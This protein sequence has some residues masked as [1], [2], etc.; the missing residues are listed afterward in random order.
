MNWHFWLKLKSN[1]KNT[2]KHK[3][4][5]ELN[6]KKNLKITKKKNDDQRTKLNEINKKIV[7]STPINIPKI[8]AEP[9]KIDKRTRQGR[10]MTPT[11]NN[12][13]PSF[14]TRKAPL[15]HSTID[16]YIGKADILQRLFT[17]KITIARSK[18]RNK[19][20]IE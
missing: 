3:H 18:S 20:T 13:I 4:Y 19:K 12:I 2:Q 1:V 15:E 5:I 17:K 9:P 16:D 7:Q 8:T 10:K 11:T 14:E 6:T